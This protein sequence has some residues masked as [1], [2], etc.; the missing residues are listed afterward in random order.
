M[1]L[2][3]SP[4]VSNLFTAL[5]QFQGEVT[6]VAKDKFGYN[7]TYKY[8]EL[9]DILEMVRPLLSKHGLALSQWP[10]GPVYLPK[11]EIVQVQEIIEAYR[12]TNTFITLQTILTHSSGEYMTKECCM[13]RMDGSRNKM[14]SPPQLDGMVYTYLRRYSLCGI[15]G[16]GA[17]EDNDAQ[18]EDN[19]AQNVSPSTFTKV[20]SYPSPA[21]SPP[22]Q[23]EKIGKERFL[24]LVDKFNEEQKEYLISFMKEND[25]ASYKD[26][27][28]ESITSDTRLCTILR[29]VR[30]K[31]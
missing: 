9:P 11:G 24:M 31:E 16:I 29:E 17:D 3:I 13:P 5:S 27:P 2:Q 26:I 6:N 21:P 23:R 15:L 28:Y 30:G 4:N 20:I 14:L 25:F 10:G 1:T 18:N 22:V 7:K 12:L 8:A 19:D